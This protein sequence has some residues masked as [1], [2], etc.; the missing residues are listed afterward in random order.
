MVT[1][2]LAIKVKEGIVLAADSR[3]NSSSPSND[4]VKILTFSHQHRY[5]AALISGTAV[6]SPSD[7]RTPDQLM[8]EIETGFGQQRLS[9]EQYAEHVHSF[10]LKHF[11]QE[12][13]KLRRIIPLQQIPPSDTTLIVVGFNEYESE[14]KVLSAASFQYRFMPP[15]FRDLTF[16]RNS[17]VDRRQQQD[18]L[19]GK[20]DCIVARGK[21]DAF[22][23]A[24][25][26]Y[27]F[28]KPQLIDAV[29]NSLF[30]PWKMPDSSSLQDA[31]YAAW[32]LIDLATLVTDE[33]ASPIRVCTM[34]CDEG[35]QALELGEDS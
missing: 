16:I 35:L 27:F 31:A 8:P 9:I 15:F 24:Y 4:A 18:L 25:R 1:L 22:L 7:P 23:A 3:Q 6:V 29:E 30:G 12:W 10:F 33:I 5:V 13:H 20:T 19:V 34:T 32:C 14:G 11:Q 26:S 21:V 17:V 2:A 28:D